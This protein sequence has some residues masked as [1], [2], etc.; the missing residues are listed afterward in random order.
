MPAPSFGWRRPFSFWDPEGGVVRIIDYWKEGLIA[1]LLGHQ[2][3]HLT[4]T[5]VIQFLNADMEPIKARRVAG[6]GKE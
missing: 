4:L 5:A 3:L 2:V 6:D 1:I